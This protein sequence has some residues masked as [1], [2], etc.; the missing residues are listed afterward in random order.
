[1]LLGNVSEFNWGVEYLSQHLSFD[2]DIRVHLRVCSILAPSSPFLSLPLFLSNAPPLLFSSASNYFPPLPSPR[3]TPKPFS[4]T[5]HPL[6]VALYTLCFL[7]GFSP[8]S[9]PLAP[10]RNVFEANIRALGSLLSAHML[11]LQSHDPT[12][13]P[14]HP[15][16]AGV[17]LAPGYKG[18]LLELAI[19]LGFRLLPAFSSGTPIPYAWV[20]LRRGV[21]PD[22]V[23]HTCTAGAGTLLLEFSALS[24]ISGIPIFQVRSH[25][26]H[27][28]T[29]LN[30]R[31]NWIPVSQSHTA[32]AGTLLLEFSALS[33]LSGIP[34]FHEKAEAAVVALYRRRSP[35]NLVGNGISSTSGVWLQRES[36]AGAGVDSFFEYLLKGYLLLGK[37]T[38]RRMFS[39]VYSGAM[40]YMA[41]RGESMVRWLLDVGIDNGH[42]GRH[43]ASSLQA[44][45][46]A[47]QVLAGQTADARVIHSGLW[48]VWKRFSFL[49]EL[50]SVTASAVH[51]VERG[52]PLRPEMAESAYFLFKATGNHTYLEIGRDI[53]AALNTVTRAGCGFAS[54]GD[55]QTHRLDDHMESFLLS[56]TLKYLYLLFSPHIDISARFV[57]STEGHLLSLNLPRIFRVVCPSED[58]PDMSPAGDCRVVAATA[59][60]D[61]DVDTDVDADMSQSPLQAP[62]EAQKPPDESQRPQS[63][64]PLLEKQQPSFESRKP[65]SESR[66]PSFE[67]RVCEDSLSA[68]GSLVDPDL[69]LRRQL[70]CEAVVGTFERDEH[71]GK[72]WYGAWEDEDKASG[73]G[74]G[75]EEE[76]REKGE[77]EERRDE[78]GER[79]EGE[80]G[81]GRL[82]DGAGRAG[83][84]GD[85]KSGMES[86]CVEGG[87]LKSGVRVSGVASNVEGERVPAISEKGSVEGSREKEAETREEGLKE[88][89]ERETRERR[90]RRMGRDE[91]KRRLER[92]RERERR[93]K[94]AEKILDERQRDMQ[95]EREL[96]RLRT[97]A[98][99]LRLMQ[100]RRDER[101]RS[102]LEEE[103]S[104]LAS[105]IRFQE[106]QREQQ[107]AA[108]A[109]AAAAAA[110]GGEEGAE[111]AGREGVGEQ[112]QC[113]AGDL[114]NIFPDA[115]AAAAAAGAGAGGT[116]DAAM[117]GR[118]LGGVVSRVIGNQ[119][120][121]C[122]FMVDASHGPSCFAWN[123][124]PAA[125]PYLQGFQTL[126]VNLYIRPSRTHLCGA[127]ACMVVSPHASPLLPARI[128][129]PPSLTNSP[130]AQEHVQ[131]APRSPVWCAW[132]DSPNP[133]QVSPFLFAFS[134][135]SAYISPYFSLFLSEH[136]VPAAPPC[137]VRLV[138]SP[139]PEND[140]SS[141]HQTNVTVREG[142][143]ERGEEE[144]GVR[145]N[146]E[147][148]E[149]GEGERVADGGGEGSGGGRGEG[150]WE[151]EKGRRGGGEGRG[152]RGRGQELVDTV[153]VN[154]PAG[155]A[156]FGPFLGNG[157][158]GGDGGDGDGG[159]YGG[160]SGGGG[161]GDA[162]DDDGYEASPIQACVDRLSN[163]GEVKGRVV[164]VMRGGCSFQQK[165]VAAQRAGAAAVIV[166][167]HVMGGRALNM[168][169][170]VPGSD[171]VTH[172]G[173]VS[174]G[175]EGTN[176]DTVTP[177]SGVSQGGEGT[178]SET[179]TTDGLMAAGDGVSSG[180]G[181]PSSAA[182]SEEGSEAAGGSGSDAVTSVKE[183]AAGDGVSPGKLSAAN[184]REQCKDQTDRKP[185]HKGP[186]K[187]GSGDKGEGEGDGV[188]RL[189]D[190]KAAEVWVKLFCPKKRTEE[191]HPVLFDVDVSVPP[192]SPLQMQQAV[193]AM[194]L[195]LKGGHLNRLLTFA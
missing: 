22:D 193:N 74:E 149:V 11:I 183:S 114:D 13:P 20:N 63:Q 120:L 165:V 27:M 73:E 188:N 142:E 128:P 187:H 14:V 10:H 140:S 35:L 25:T 103:V 30:A 33:N 141:G 98:A 65:S 85:D 56:E 115:A 124:L 107:L 144:R 81:V 106:R 169:P 60:M 152:G 162:G 68:L 8:C 2:L 185:H 155:A 43:Y 175:G 62:N 55:V 12:L 34:I 46:P 16:L 119:R 145:K 71:G 59:D 42:L 90:E 91:R 96:R 21:L 3:Q 109:V 130:G 108:A 64:P 45:W 186:K 104:R 122:Y 161:D 156:E 134:P 26:P 121:L 191:D 133:A 137:V 9:L 38:F 163:P 150:G 181:N 37:S 135:P 17:H 48:A 138:N 61:A 32:G 86:G 7:N 195:L 29:E 179:V 79:T 5:F 189:D 153:S 110:A 123:A 101:W 24:N 131:A 102:P 4:L 129:L 117:G 23:T 82:R 53:A 190:G 132:L 157:D 125:F 173:G 69:A 146:G 31:E 47:M 84:K 49:P 113:P 75:G 192:Q 111:G 143:E 178:D 116:G 72:G 51:P 36:T 180:K 18:R 174:E 83:E 57:F 66:K 54:V 15:S 44:F 76:A 40:R 126:T 99:G 151:T 28:K 164:V 97:Q 89:E 172:E 95:R 118:R 70:V 148:A 39:K 105:F 92:A 112:G 88:M 136:K 80:G 176:S 194:I 77:G 6:P 94:V 160:G 52:Y 41:V 19:D 170:D 167:N 67:A 166:V 168:A 177:D 158:D 93:K 182:A 159:S 78:V 184:E 171:T 100:G 1:M 147:S 139:P 127:F 50:F 58:H 87:E 154:L